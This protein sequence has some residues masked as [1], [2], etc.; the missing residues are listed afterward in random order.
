MTRHGSDLKT[1]TCVNV[2]EVLVMVLLRVRMLGVVLMLLVVFVDVV[3]D[4]VVGVLQ[5]SSDHFDNMMI[6]I[7]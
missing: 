3:V 6:S 5:N 1:L 7:T 2:L 4:V